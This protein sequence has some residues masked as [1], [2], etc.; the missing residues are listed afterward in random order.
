[1]KNLKATILDL[2]YVNADANFFEQ[3]VS[4]ALTFDRNP[5]RVWTTTPFYAVLIKHPTEGYILYDTGA[6]PAK[7][8]PVNLQA[9]CEIVNDGDRNIVDQ[10]AK[11]NVKPEDI[12]HVI[13]SHYHIDHAGALGLFVKHATIYVDRKEAESAYTTVLAT[14]E[15][16][17]HGFYYRPSVLQEAKNIQYIDEDCELFEGVHVINVK[18]HTAGT[19]ALLLELESGN[20]L[21]TSDACNME[22]NY[23]GVPGGIVYDSLSAVEA[24]KKL[25]KIAKQYNVKQVWFSHDEKQFKSMKKAPEFY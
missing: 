15:A 25:H 3:N 10:L 6:T 16:P 5:Q 24:V 13:L 2:G 9:V 7:E 20:V 12:K 11:V 8:W 22:S 23:N 1:M 17:A 19:L 14:T 4:V 21:I 18:G